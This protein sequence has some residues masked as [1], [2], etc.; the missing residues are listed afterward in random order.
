M[1]GCGHVLIHN[2]GQACDLAIAS[3][4]RT[5]RITNPRSGC[6]HKAWGGAQRNPRY[7]SVK[8]FKPAERA[9]AEEPSLM[10]AENLEC[11][12]KA[13]RRRRFGWVEL[14]AIQSGVAL[15]FAGA[16]QILSPASR[17]QSSMVALTLGLMPQALCW[18][19]LRA[20]TE[21]QPADASSISISSLKPRYSQRNNAIG[22][23]PFF[24]K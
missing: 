6:Q 7:A 21:R 17:A 4:Q 2:W 13:K 22:R 1:N 8:V 23:L 24:H 19:A 3:A 12:G 10:S 9:T 20:L 5:R 16:L 18:R 11:A 14:I 15:R